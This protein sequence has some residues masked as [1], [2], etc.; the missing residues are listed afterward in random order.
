VAGLAH[1]LGRLVTPG[2]SPVVLPEGLDTPAVVI[3]LDLVER[4]VAM[5]AA[6]MA[7]RGVA[8]RPHAKTHKSVRLARMQLDAGAAGITVGTLGEAEVMAAGGVDDLFIAYPLF[9]SAA[10]ARRLRALHE[11]ASVRVGVDSV[12]GAEALGAAVR[13]SGAPLDVLVEIDCGLG[14]TGVVGAEAA[15]DVAIA[16]RSVG[17]HVIGAFTHGGHGYAS[18]EASRPAAADEVRALTEATAALQQAG[19]DVTVS[20]AGSTPTAAGSAIGGVTEERPGTYVFADRLQDALRSPGWES[21][22]LVVA[23]TVVSVGSGSIVIDAGAKALA[24]EPSPLLDGLAVIPELGGATVV[25]AYDYHGVVSLPEGAPLP[26]V[27]R[28]VGVVPNH[29]CPV[30]NLAD[31]LVVTRSG[32]FFE[33]WAVDAR[34]RNG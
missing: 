17:L 21:I 31:E 1:E 32:T 34:A 9:A 16:A 8:L 18:P 2:G 4:N 25:R 5:M 19:F 28:V 6:L 3:D 33:R 14:R 30:V 23:A 27:G 10:K 29:V 20:S 11:T 12:A 24:R 13:G 15:V 22:G 26:T 7:G